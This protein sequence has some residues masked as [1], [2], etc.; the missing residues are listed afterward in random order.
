MHYFDKK[1]YYQRYKISGRVSFRLQTFYLG[2][3]KRGGVSNVP[4]KILFEVKKED[5]EF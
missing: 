5:M 3:I 2:N 1:I 4:A